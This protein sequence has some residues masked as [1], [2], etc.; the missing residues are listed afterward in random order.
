MKIVQPTYEIRSH[1]DGTRMLELIEEA[2]R[3]CYKS[4][5][6]NNTE[7][8]LK[9]L[10][11]THHD[12]PFEH[13]GF[14]VNFTCDRGV[15]H[16]LVRHRIASF[17]QSSTRYCNYA[18]DKFNNELTFVQP[19]FWK[20][21]TLKY[22]MWLTAMKLAETQYMALIEQ[23]AKP[24]EARSVL[25]NSLMTEVYTTA[26]LREWRHIFN[27]RCS[28]AAHPQIA[29]LML[30]LLAAVNELIPVVFEDLY[31]KYEDR[32]IKSI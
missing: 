24:Q 30:P 18:K 27:L 21:D 16:E 29:E 20:T 28:K 6:R 4:E 31:S 32:I 11:K 8:F 23:G 2:A 26:N 9:R 17:S 19:S 10:L 12:T 5:P 13:A 15:S 1:V 22:S 3:N 25:P 14:T 7:E